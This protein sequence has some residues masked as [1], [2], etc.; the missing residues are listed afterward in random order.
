MTIKEL[1]GRDYKKAVVALDQA[2]KKQNVPK[3]ELEQLKRIVELRGIIK[4]LC[5]SFVDE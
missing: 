4:E 1:T 5:S 2:K 3:E